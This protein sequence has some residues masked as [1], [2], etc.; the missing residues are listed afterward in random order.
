MRPYG[1]VEDVQLAGGDAL[2]GA[3]EGC[4][5]GGDAPGDKQ[6]AEDGEQDDEQGDGEVEEDGLEDRRQGFGAGLFGEEEHVD[7]RQVAEGAKD[8][9]T[10]IVGVGASAIDRRGGALNTIGKQGVGLAGDII[11]IAGGSEQA[12]VTASNEIG[13]ASLS[14]TGGAGRQGEQAGQAVEVD[15]TGE[16]PEHLAFGVG[17]RGSDGDD[18]LVELL[19]RGTEG[20]QTGLP[21]RP[22]NKDSR[23]R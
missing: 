19:E 5:G 20:R 3:G 18:A 23:T 8:L 6:G 12:E 2:G 11:R 9:N 13:L 7:I 22:R 10:G 21:G 17:E 14:K 1:L 4:N 15:A 16:Q